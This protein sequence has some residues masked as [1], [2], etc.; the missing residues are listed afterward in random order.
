M[1]ID[2][3]NIDP[4]APPK[5][6]IKLVSP[7]NEFVIFYFFEDVDWDNKKKVITY[8]KLIYHTILIFYQIRKRAWNYN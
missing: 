6:I 2:V 7:Y 5:Q 8:Y 3:E 1:I 4:A